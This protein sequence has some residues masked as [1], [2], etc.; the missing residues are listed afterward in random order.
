MKFIFRTV[1]V[2]PTDRAALAGCILAGVLAVLN[3]VAMGQIVP[4]P[5][6]SGLINPRAVVYSPAT[7]KVYAV[8]TS[9]GAVTIYDDAH[10]TRHA[11]KVGAE[12][13]SVAVN[14]SNGM[15]YVANGGDGTV[16]VLDGASDA[17]VATVEVGS[18][19]YSIAVNAKTG[20]VYVTHTFGNELSILNGVN[21]RASHLKTGSHD[22]I[23]ID[24][25]TDTIYLL[26]YESGT[27]SVVDGE[28]QTVRLKQAG[29]HAWGLALDE[30]TGT[31]YAARIEARQVAVLGAD[32]S[33]ARYLPSGP[34][35]C[36]LTMNARA[37]V[38]YVANYGGNSVSAVN[39]RDGHAIATV[40]VGERPKAIAFDAR[41]N[42]VYVANTQGDSVTAIDARTNTVIATLPAGKNPYALAVVPGSSRLYVAD[43]W[44][45]QGSTVVDLSGIRVN[46]Q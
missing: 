10:G 33:S 16:S 14:A 23:A 42:L 13:I 39:L 34:I 44:D 30:Q 24:D 45:E 4:K 31:L 36:A 43:E 11:V 22:L 28:Q 8:D 38:L 1:L 7:E 26:G 41:R 15:A 3:Q 37:D 46:R 35:P 2:L 18:H 6:S 9:H 27:V 5:P 21:N 29:N 25:K 12:P 19:P 17:V 20:K 40:S 32:S